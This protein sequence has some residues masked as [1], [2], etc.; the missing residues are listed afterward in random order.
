[1]PRRPFIL[2]VVIVAL[3]LCESAALGTSTA[4]SFLANLLEIFACGF[5]ALMAFR[6][7]RR[8]RG[9]SRPFWQIVGAGIALWGV[10][11]LGWMY[12][13]VVR[14]TEPPTTS[15]IRF[16]FGLEII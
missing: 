6:A 10:A 1:M 5:A 7:S 15:A 8:G 12:Y 4:G 9:L 16:L 2:G 11:N 14:H 13:E 3:H